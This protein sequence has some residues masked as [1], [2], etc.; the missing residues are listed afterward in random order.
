MLKTVSGY[1]STPLVAEEPEAVGK[2]KFKEWEDILTTKKY[3]DTPIGDVLIY[4]QKLT[5]HFQP[6][7][8]NEIGWRKT[9]VG[10]LFMTLQ[11]PQEIWVNWGGESLGTIHLTAPTGF[12]RGRE[13]GRL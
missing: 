11:N 6:K 10:Y 13:F 2:N 1:E 3:V 9:G 4:P 8:N 7:V 5:D 12:W